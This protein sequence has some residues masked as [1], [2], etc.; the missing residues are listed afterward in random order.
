MTPYTETELQQMRKDNAEDWQK[1]ITFYRQD[2]DAWA[3]IFAIFMQTLDQN[4]HTRLIALLLQ[5]PKEV[6]FNVINLACL[7]FKEVMIRESSDATNQTANQEGT[8]T[9]V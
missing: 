8:T 4:D 9:G 2:I 3:S 1:T 5:T 7:G 6:V